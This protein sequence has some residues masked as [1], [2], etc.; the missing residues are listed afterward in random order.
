MLACWFATSAIM[1]QQ[2]LLGL[3]TVSR[4]ILAP[5]SGHYINQDQ[6]EVIEEA[7]KEMMFTSPSY[8]AR[9]CPQ[10]Y[11]QFGSGPGTSHLHPEE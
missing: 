3:S 8:K 10:P 2:D 1:L 6:P 5:N 9:I 11:T 4:Q 7:V